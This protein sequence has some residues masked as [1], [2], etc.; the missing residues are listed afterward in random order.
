[1]STTD[2][3][4]GFPRSLDVSKW[5]ERH[6][7]GDVPSRWP[8]G[9]DQFTNRIKSS[10]LNVDH[11]SRLV[12]VTGRIAPTML[13]AVL[14]RRSPGRQIGL[15]WDENTA[16]SMSILHPNREMYTGVIWTPDLLAAEPKGSFS[17]TRQILRSM[18]GIWVLS[19][20][21]VA[22]MQ[23]FLGKGGPPVHLVRFGVD[24]KFY[25]PAPYPTV[26]C[27]V[28]AGGDRH[29][30]PQALFEVLSRVKA[31][32]P[33][34]QI[35]VQTKS[36]LPAPNGVTKVRS[37]SHR[38]VRDLYARASVVAVATRPN[39]HGSGMTVALEGMAT[40]RPVVVSGT[41][42]MDDYVADAQ[43]GFLTPVGDS[44]QM[45]SRILELLSDCTAGEAMGKNAR[46]AV[47]ARM[48]TLHLVW[49]LE[50]VMKLDV[51]DA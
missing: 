27:V 19:K 12:S 42:G 3:E 11:P 4:I 18:T 14:S 25:T 48:T 1:M 26:P 35:I 46:A 45:A 2:L 47:E 37:L 16:R 44:E 36:E 28:S 13:R 43:T 5:K 24:E 8:Y 22:P 41:H 40:G 39:L 20:A 17:R 7:S 50:R 10:Y 29:R 33:E 15:T 9:L 6:E 21:Q 30:D 34:A 31:E 38:E 32:M 51:N 23:N 49:A